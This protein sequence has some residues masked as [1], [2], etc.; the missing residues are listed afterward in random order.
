M[1]F[2]ILEINSR[3]ATQVFYAAEYLPFTNDDSVE[4]V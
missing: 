2:F 3:F 4:V 1:N